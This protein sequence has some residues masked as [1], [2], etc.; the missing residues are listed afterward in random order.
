MYIFIY[1][2]KQKLKQT[3]SAASVIRLER[4]IVRIFEDQEEFND[5]EVHTTI[6]INDMMRL[7]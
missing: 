1:L 4:K 3:I 5:H 6:V 2:K 7:S